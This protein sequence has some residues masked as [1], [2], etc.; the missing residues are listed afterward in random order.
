MDNS[1]VHFNLNLSE[2]GYIP[3][4]EINTVIQLA[5]YLEKPLLIE[6]PPGTGKTSLALSVAKSL[7]LDLIRIQCYEGIDSIQVIGEFNYKKQLLQLQKNHLDKSESEDIF[8]KEFFIP[9]PLYKS[10][11]S[12]DRVVLL[13]DELDAAD[14][15]FTA[16]LLEAL[17]EG[18][19]TIPEF[20]TIKSKKIPHVFLTS[21]KRQELPEALLRRCLYIYID[22]P[23][24]T[25]EEEIVR[26]HCPV[27]DNLLNNLVR[28]V[29]EIRKLDLRKKP[30]I[31]ESIDW[32]KSLMMLKV[33]NITREV[34]DRTIN[35]VIKHQEDINLVKENLSEII[36]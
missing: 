9:R 13:I 1:K 29:Q 8:S 34:I 26:Y 5:L 17:G 32:M 31:S 3:S 27:N 7:N 11:T 14:E 35:V 19:I 12:P 36:Q 4:E 20:G 33:D 21:N 23:N 25:R 16:F 18:Q 10:F 30:S 28:I 24:K 15:E 22:Y 2:H 6:G